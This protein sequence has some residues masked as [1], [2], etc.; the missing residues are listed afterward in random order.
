[1]QEE[2]DKCLSVGMDD[3]IT[4]PITFL[5]FQSKIES[6]RSKKISNS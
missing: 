2:K 3:Y 1:L 5:T 6:L 4:K